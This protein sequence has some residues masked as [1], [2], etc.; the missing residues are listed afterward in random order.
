MKVFFE[1]FSINNNLYVHVRLLLTSL[2]AT[3]ADERLFVILSPVLLHTL[4]YKYQKL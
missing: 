1:S 2:A 3:T 4:C